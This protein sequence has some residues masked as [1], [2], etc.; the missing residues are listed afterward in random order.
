MTAK[1]VLNSC[2]KDIVMILKK[3]E[4]I[5]VSGIKSGNRLKFSQIFSVCNTGDS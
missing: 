5:I 1:Y 4:I 2:N 3:K